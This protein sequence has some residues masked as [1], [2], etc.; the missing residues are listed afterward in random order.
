LYYFDSAKSDSKAL[1]MIMLPSYTILEV[2]TAAYNRANC[3]DLDHPS[4]RCYSLSAESE[5]SKEDWIEKLSSAATLAN[6]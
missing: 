6:F 1:G 3:F 4:A 2:P 5:G